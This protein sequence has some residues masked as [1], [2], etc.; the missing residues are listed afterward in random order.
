MNE[1][2]RGQQEQENKVIYG[3]VIYRQRDLLLIPTCI[4]TY[5]AIHFWQR[6]Y[7][8]EGLFLGS[9]FEMRGEWLLS[10]G[11]SRFFL[12][13]DWRSLHD[14]GSLRCIVWPSIHFLPLNGLCLCKYYLSAALPAS[15]SWFKGVHHLRICS[16]SVWPCMVVCFWI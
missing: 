7:L 6:M 2:W 3:T 15:P 11:Y 16:C 4:Y 9:S 1:T 13:W 5:P 14:A 8:P 10:H 12:R